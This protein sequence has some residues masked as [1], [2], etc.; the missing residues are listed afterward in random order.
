MVARVRGSVTAE[1]TQRKAHTVLAACAFMPCWVSLTACDRH[2]CRHDS[3][4]GMRPCQLL[5][6]SN[7]CPPAQLGT[8]VLIAAA[9]ERHKQC[10]AQSIS[11]GAHGHARNAMARKHTIHCVVCAWH[12]LAGAHAAMY[13]QAPAATWPQRASGTSAVH[14]AGASVRALPRPL[15]AG[16]LLARISHVGVRLWQREDADALLVSNAFEGLACRV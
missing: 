2:T 7:I 16:L 6:K 11:D 14:Q 9:L 1:V 15:T 4:H 5:S 3:L 8:A 13:N 12:T 10:G